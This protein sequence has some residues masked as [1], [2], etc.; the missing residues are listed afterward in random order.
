VLALAIGCGG[1][2]LGR[3]GP[4]VSRLLGDAKTWNGAT[5]AAAI[6][7]AALLSVFLWLGARGRRTPIAIALGLG[8]VPWTVSTLS[9]AVRSSAVDLERLDDPRSAVE[10][11]VT[12]TDVIESEII[13]G[14]LSGL[15]LAGVALGLALAAL[16]QRA[17]GRSLFGG[18][19]G[20]AGATFVLAPAAVA[21][22]VDVRSS[23]VAVAASLLGAIACV[24]G[25]L[26]VGR[27]E[28][29]ARSAALGAGAAFAAALAMGP[30]AASTHGVAIAGWFEAIA[31]AGEVDRQAELRALSD[32][33]AALTAMA[34]FGALASLLS[35][36][37]LALF[38]AIKTKR[39]RAGHAAGAVAAVIGALIAVALGVIAMSSWSRVVELLLSDAPPF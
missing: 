17:P 33:L 4:V 2:W 13:G 29:H 11:V 24:L 39:V 30:A 35:G 20:L 5:Y 36:G 9:A 3:H 18:L 38:G 8:L 15:L 27:D 23:A 1:V 14:A 12:I 21:I 19:A 22:M 34:R 31:R 37:T 7:A 10:L 32:S 26:A 16:A 25:G 28:P 6:V